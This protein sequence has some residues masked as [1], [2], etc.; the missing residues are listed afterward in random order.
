MVDALSPASLP[1]NSANAGS[2]SLV[3]IPRRYSTG[4]T[5]ATLGDRRAHGGRIALVKRRPSRRSLT[6]GACIS[7]SPAVVVTVRG[8]LT[9][10]RT[11]SACPA[12]SRMP[13]CWLTY[14]STSALSAVNSMRR[15]PSRTSASKSSLSASC[16]ACSEATILNIAAYLSVDGLTAV[17]LQQPG[18]YAALLTPTQ[19]HNFRL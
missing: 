16:S 14:S 10:L 12:S 11:T 13:A 15:A 4:S 17:R 5:S 3:E 2:K 1:K 19:I 6:R 18:G 8:S 7:S 9:P